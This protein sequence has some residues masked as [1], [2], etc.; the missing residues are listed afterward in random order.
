MGPDIS[1]KSIVTYK[2][3]PK[4]LSLIHFSLSGA[5]N[6]EAL[7]PQSRNIP[8]AWPVAIFRIMS[9]KIAMISSF[10]IRELYRRVSAVKT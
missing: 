8:Y 2:K 5:L 1:T 7:L 3:Y 10:D 9:D 6:N 4:G